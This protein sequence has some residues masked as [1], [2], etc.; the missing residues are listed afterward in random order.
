MSHHA[1]FNLLIPYQDVIIFFLWK[2]MKKIQNLKIHGIF[3]Q[4]NF[5][6]DVLK[7]LR[8]LKD[9]V[10]EFVKYLHDKKIGHLNQ[11]TYFEHEIDDVIAYTR[12]VLEHK[13]LPILDNKASIYDNMY[14]KLEYLLT[15]IQS[16]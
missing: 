12:S 15:T 9:E 11:L 7:E 4:N 14:H 1:A 13:H 10:S 2:T 6:N 16:R 3:Q 8:I 5:H